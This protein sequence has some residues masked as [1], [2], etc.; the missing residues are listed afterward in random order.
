MCSANNAHRFAQ[1]FR[2]AFRGVRRCVCEERNFRFHL[3]FGAYVVGFATEFSFS[4]VEWM[5]L[6]LCIGTVLCAELINSAMERAVDRISTEQH[7]LSAAAKDYA[8]AAVL[9]LTVAVTVVGVLLFW[10]PTVWVSLMQQ[11][12][13]DIW[14]PCVLLLSFI[15]AWFFVFRR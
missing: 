9:V 12:C 13:R 6:C 7:P 14:Q 10:Q 15:P 5:V 11:W 3:V 4:R 2:D 8:A 1:G